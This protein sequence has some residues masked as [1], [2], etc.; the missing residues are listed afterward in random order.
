[1]KKIG[2]FYYADR[3]LTP[4]KTIKQ[5]LALKC[6]HIVEL[7]LFSYKR[8]RIVPFWDVNRT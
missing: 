4:S 2:K 6:G 8:L 7:L 1:M 3:P 5:E